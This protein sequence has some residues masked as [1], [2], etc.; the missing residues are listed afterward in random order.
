MGVTHNIYIVPKS[1]RRVKL[2]E[3]INFI[4]SLAKNGHIEKEYTIWTGDEQKIEHVNRNN[5]Y[6]SSVLSDFYGSWLERV[7]DLDLTGN[8]RERNYL[9]KVHIS[10]RSGIFK[11]LDVFKYTK[12]D[13]F[14][15]FIIY[16]H[17]S[18]NLVLEREYFEGG[19]HI[20]EYIDIRNINSVIKSSGK[21][22]DSLY[23]IQNE[24]NFTDFYDN[25]KDLFEEY[26]IG[27]YFP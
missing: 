27:E 14:P 5:F 17:D 9:F 13:N 22:V 1:N 21:G 8:C 10:R 7:P 12:L 3:I 18:K 26:E 16:F 4:T 11:N 2:E 19:K 24:S 6:D 23:G 25:V 20:Y 15:I